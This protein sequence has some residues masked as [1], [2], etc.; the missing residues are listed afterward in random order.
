VG[1]AAVLYVMGASVTKPGH[2][3]GLERFA[4]GSLK[5]LT[6]LDEARSLLDAGVRELTLI[7]QNVN[8]WTGADEKGRSQGLD[9]LV[10]ALDLAREMSDTA[11]A[12]TVASRIAEVVDD[13]LA[14]DDRPGVAFSLLRALVDLQS[15]H[16]P[17]R[18]PDLVRRS[19]QTYG[20]DPHNL[21][22]TIEL[23]IALASTSESRTT[24]RTRQAELWRDTAAKAEGIVRASFLEKALDVA[25]THG[26]KELARELRV[27]I[28]SLTEEDL[29][30]KTVSA[31]IKIDRDKVDRFHAAFVRFDSWEESLTAFGSYGPPGGDPETMERQVEQQMKAHPLQYLVT[32]VVFDSDFGAPVFHATD[33]ASHKLAAMAQSQWMASQIWAV[34]A[35]TILERFAERYGRPPRDDLANFFTSALID[36]GMAERIALAFELWWDDRPDESAHMLVP[37]LEAAVRNLARE[38]GLPIIREPHSSKPG[39]VRPLGELLYQLHERFG[40]EAWRTYLL[41]LLVDPL[42]L[43]LRNVIAHGVRARIE[44]KDAALLLHA[45][46][47]LRLV[48]VG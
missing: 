29:C 28:Q 24:L 1:A 19:A 15:E 39:T 46:A 2:G 30:L 8:A 20:G 3:Q 10:R 9:G 14:R 13:E 27:E 4:S 47:F 22:S 21:E 42:G 35:V 48:Q 32:K 33:D 26:L 12:Q 23:E 17:H 34:S 11:L 7:G 40:S 41:H 45:A 31:E 16:R 5:R 6:V 37:R 44:R 36:S 43:N 18:L 25:R 38:I